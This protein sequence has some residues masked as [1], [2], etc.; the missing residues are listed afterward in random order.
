MD[1]EVI[2]CALELL[3]SW[4]AGRRHKSVTHQCSNLEENEYLMPYHWGKQVD[5]HE[6]WCLRLGADGEDE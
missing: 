4:S 3:I 5:G 2:K 1:S 6:E